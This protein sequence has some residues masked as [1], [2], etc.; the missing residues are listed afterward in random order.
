MPEYI[1]PFRVS[2]PPLIR[3][4]KQLTEWT[5]IWSI[6]SYQQESQDREE[7]IRERRRTGRRPYKGVWATLGRQPETNGREVPDI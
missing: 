2:F 6:G 3:Q 4:S 7:K 1:L 5:K